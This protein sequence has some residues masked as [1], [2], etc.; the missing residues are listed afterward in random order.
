MRIRGD[1]LP[2][3]P[4]PRFLRLP[5]LPADADETA[6]TVYA[7]ELCD[8]PCDREVVHLVY[9]DDRGRQVAPAG[10]IHNAPL[11]PRPAEL[12]EF[13]DMLRHQGLRV[14]ARQVAFVWQSVDD[15]PADRLGVEA[16]S[17]GLRSRLGA[18]P[19][20]LRA[21]WWRTPDGYVLLTGGS[22]RVTPP[23]PRTSPR[24]PHG[25]GCGS[26]G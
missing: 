7:D 20:R 2:T 13:V 10:R 24:S 18:G 3:D 25:P 14:R 4:D 17:A 9:L 12:D 5:D 19:L 6:L 8:E 22:E 16:W 1:E 26:A 15:G 11:L 21:L 23:V